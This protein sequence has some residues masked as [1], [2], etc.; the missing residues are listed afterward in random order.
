MTETQRNFAILLAIA[1]VGYVAYQTFSITAA[2]IFFVISILFMIAISFALWRLYKSREGTIAL[3]ATKWRLLLQ[4]SAVLGYVTLV[5]GLL[6]P[7]WASWGALFALMWFTLLGACIAG[8]HTAWQQRT[9]G[10]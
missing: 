7:G 5:T 8:I 9:T 2:T 1:V 4:L 3:M 6:F 10:W